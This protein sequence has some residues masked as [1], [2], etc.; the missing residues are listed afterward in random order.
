[1]TCD[2]WS[3]GVIM[4]ILCSGTPP[5]STTPGNKNNISK[6]MKYRII[7]G[8]YSFTGTCWTNVSTDAKELIR[9]M[10]ETNP[11]QRIPINDIMDSNWMKVKNMC[12]GV[13][14]LKKLKLIK[15]FSIFKGYL[16]VPETPLNSMEIFKENIS[17]LKELNENMSKALNE[18][19]IDTEQ[20]VKLKPKEAIN[21]R[22]FEQRMNKKNKKQNETAAISE[23]MV[24]VEMLDKTEDESKRQPSTFIDEDDIT[25]LN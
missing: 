15:E 11:I 25:D 21:N 3:L 17:D 13:T 5:F 4:Y 12:Y 18:I 19:T 16:D 1:M 23:S 14:S 9:K 7:S 2:I 8:L 22:L 20:T 24:S 6:G 10:L